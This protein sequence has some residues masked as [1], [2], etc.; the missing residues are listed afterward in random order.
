[1]DYV[2]K[3]QYTTKNIITYKLPNS[4]ISGDQKGRQDVDTVGSG[5]G[6]YISEGYATP[7]TWEKTCRSCKTIYKYSDGKELKVNDGNTWI[8]IQPVG[9]VL[10]ITSN[11]TETE[12]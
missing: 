5:E 6:Y 3:K 2:T 4:T 10:D 8:Q 7:I 9:K 12:E 11:N 1:M